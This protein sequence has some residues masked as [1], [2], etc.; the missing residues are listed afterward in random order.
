MKR[1]TSIAISASLLCAAALANAAGNQL[2]TVSVQGI[3]KMSA[4][5]TP[6]DSRAVC[7]AWHE[8]IRR[9][10]TPREIGMLFGAR[11]SYP[12]YAASFDRLQARYSA[13]QGQFAATHA[14][15]LNAIAAK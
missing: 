5:C 13:L 2:S 1:F 8:E 12:N 15:E 6:P 11:T 9:N 4:A 14:K 10:F 7:S 3:D